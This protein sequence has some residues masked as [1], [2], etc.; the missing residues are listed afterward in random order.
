MGDDLLE[1]FQKTLFNMENK[2]ES[3][4]VDLSTGKVIHIILR[5]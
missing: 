2:I 5:T 1:H 4:Q 3:M